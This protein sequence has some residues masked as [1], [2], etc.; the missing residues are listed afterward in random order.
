MKEITVEGYLVTIEKDPESGTFTVCVPQLPGCIVQVNKE[1]EARPR[2]RRAMGE[3][4]AEIASR[5]PMRKRSD[6]PD[7]DPGNGYGTKKAR[8]L[9]EIRK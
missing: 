8:P 3:Y 5:K 9:P 4:L 2:I 1:E 7:S 6:R